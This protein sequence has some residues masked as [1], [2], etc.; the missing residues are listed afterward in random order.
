MIN[1]GVTAISEAVSQQ[2][3]SYQLSVA[4]RLIEAQL[5]ESFTDMADDMITNGEEP[6][7]AEPLNTIPY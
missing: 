6:P 3:K 2:A 7:E 1:E 4:G 5:S